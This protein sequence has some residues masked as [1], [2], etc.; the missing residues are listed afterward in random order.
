MNPWAGPLFVVGIWQRMRRMIFGCLLTGF[1]VAGTGWLMAQS[2]ALIV[3]GMSPSPED[4][5]VFQALADKTGQLLIA[6]GL[7][8]AQIQI[9]GDHVT[10]QLVLDKLRA[11]TASTND[12]FWL[13]LYGVSG[14]SRGGQPALQVG[15][16]RLTADDLKTA[17]DA[18]PAREFVF[19][20][21]GNAGGFLPVL[22]DRRRT[23][24]SATQ[25]DG[26]PDQPRYPDLWLEVFG[27]NPK[28][29]FNRIAAQAA[30][31]V[32][33]TYSSSHLAQSEHSLLADP[34]TGKILGPPFG[35][36]LQGTNAP[37]PAN[38]PAR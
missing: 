33:A 35:V 5:A 7:P 8:P 30:A 16:P 12:E 32:D 6:R 1:S 15:G 36:D 14:K 2:G 19:I 26:E 18:I 22:Q 11:V 17:L 10:R 34:A 25:A 4:A 31:R 21:T 38:Q 3:T 37:A 13:V 28:A 20:G 29:P 24:L 27:E 9:L 23:V